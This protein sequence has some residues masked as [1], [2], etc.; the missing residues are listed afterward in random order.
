MAARPKSR[1]KHPAEI[2]WT[3]ELGFTGTRTKLKIGRVYA[4]DER[5]AI[6]KAIRE[7]GITDPEHQRRLMARPS[8]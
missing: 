1:R 3:I 5:T 7:F 2:A 8:G 4:T 6:E